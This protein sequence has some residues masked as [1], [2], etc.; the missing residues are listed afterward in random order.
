[1]AN[2]DL[3]ISPNY[4]SWNVWESLREIVQNA[5]DENDKGNK[6][7]VRWA[8]DVLTIENDGSNLERRHLILGESDKSHALGTR[9]HYGEGFKIALATLARLGHK[10]R[11][12]VKGE[13]WHPEVAFSE[14]FGTHLLRI[15]T[16]P[17]E[18]TTKV[19]YRI[20]GISKEDY[21]NLC[22]R[23]LP[24]CGTYTKVS[25]P[26]GDV[27]T[28]E[29]HKGIVYVKDI[30]VHYNKDLSYGFNFKNLKLDRDRKMANH[31]DLLY[32][33]RLCL[34]G[35]IANGLNVNGFVTVLG[36]DDSLE[37]QAFSAYTGAAA[38]KAVLTETMEK[39]HGDALLVESMTDIPLADSVGKKPVLVSRALSRSLGLGE[40]LSQLRQVNKSSVKR[41][42][43][44]SEFDMDVWREAAR[45][46]EPLLDEVE[47]R[48]QVVEFNS[49][50]VLGT[51]NAS[52]RTI[53]VSLTCFAKGPLEIVHTVVHELAHREHGEHDMGFA[54]ALGVLF[55]KLLSLHKV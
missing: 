7:S 18:D 12:Q 11:V 14:Q 40:S 10:V 37:A 25:T 20:P 33:M 45:I 42:L 52:T 32:E 36:N 51:F 38:T 6:M 34:D 23:I 48:L 50:K 22:D 46:L 26:N 16:T 55:C 47:Y 35:A 39:M 28:D 54:D 49:D 13:T 1:M 53:N 3:T 29:K 24:L 17:R 8:K 31:Y 15:R 21:K 41:V 19:A 5:L 44:P 9:G 30:F 4:A 27:L 43:Q 2:F